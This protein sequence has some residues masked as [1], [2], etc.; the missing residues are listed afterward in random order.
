[1]GLTQALARCAVRHAH[2][3][4]VEVPGQWLTRAAVERQVLGQTW[5]L[6]VAPA[7]ADVLAVCGTPWPEMAEVVARLWEDLPGPR[8]RIEILTPEAAPGALATAQADLLD[9][10]RQY[11]DARSRGQIPKVEPEHAG[12]GGMEHGEHGGHDDT[13]HGGHAGMDHGGMDM[14]PVGIPLAHG[15]EDRD[16]LEM[17]VLHVRLGPVLAHWPGGLVLRCSLQGDVIVE[18]EASLV[19]PADH[20]DGHRPDESW[21]ARRCDNVVSLLALAGWDGGA[22]HARRVRDSLLTGVDPGR[23]VNELGRLRRRIRRSWL[24]RWSLRRVR[25]L[26]QADLAQHGLPGYLRGDTYDRLLAT[27]ER[28]I[29]GLAGDVEGALGRSW[30]VP[31]AG[32]PHLVT[33]LDLA[34]ARLVVASLDLEALPSAVEV[35][36]A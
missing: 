14:A 20:H 24:L 8:S 29:R 22:A 33:G 18:A 6:A 1:L 36:S 26:T 16:G 23:A 9:P 4:V 17:D 7:N 15:G 5:R 31:L 30:S 10:D 28:A 13:E 27:V 2:V 35:L 34:T 32:I 11:E 3:L 19:D 12:H 21:A 25:H